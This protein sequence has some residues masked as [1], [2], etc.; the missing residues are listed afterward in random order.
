MYIKRDLYLTKTPFKITYEFKWLPIQGIYCVQTG[1]CSNY[2]GKFKSV[3]CNKF[4]KL[5]LG[6]VSVILGKERILSWKGKDPFLE[7]KG[8]FPRKGKDPFL[9]QERSSLQLGKVSVILGKERILSFPRMVKRKASKGERKGFIPSPFL[10][11]LT[12]KSF[13]ERFSCF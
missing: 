2:D 7:R 3:G 11:I 12:R 4:T 6:K 10:Y 1:S 13:F 5:Q 9:S 8:S